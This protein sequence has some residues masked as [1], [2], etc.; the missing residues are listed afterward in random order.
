MLK[1]L[2][3][4]LQSLQ[5]IEYSTT[6]EK[7]AMSQLAQKGASSW[8]NESVQNGYMKRTRKLITE[9]RGIGMSMEADLHESFLKWLLECGEVPYANVEGAVEDEIADL[10]TILIRM[11]EKQKEKYALDKQMAEVPGHHN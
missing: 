8:V 9:M 3:R 11:G 10:K 2:N 6:P 1:V 4:M 5:S 7:G